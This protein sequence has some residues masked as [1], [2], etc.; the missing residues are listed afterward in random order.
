MPN[1]LPLAVTTAVD[2]ANSGDT[3]R[4]L[5]CFSAGGSVND[6]GRIFTGRE[7]IRHWSDQEFIGVKVSLD[8]RDSSRAAG[9]TVITA[10]VGGSGFNGPSHFTFTVRD[11]LILTMKITA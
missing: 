9:D 8:V 5:D 4:F 11:G 3:D 2:A 10:Q 7:A 6:W 1:D